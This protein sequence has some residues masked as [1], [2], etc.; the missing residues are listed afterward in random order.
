MLLYYFTLF[1]GWMVLHCV[2]ICIPVCSVCMCIIFIYLSVDEYLGCFHILAIVHFDAVNIW[3]HTSLWNR[4]FIFSGYMLRSGITGSY[5]N[6]IFS[7]LS[8]FHAT[9]HSSCANLHSHQKWKKVLFCY[10]LSSICY[11]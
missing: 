2:C 4:V 7:F 10:T 11:L 5:G 3:V 8:N 9:F 1:Y 6:S